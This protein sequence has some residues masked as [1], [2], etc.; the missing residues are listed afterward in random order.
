MKWSEAESD[1]TDR[2]RD[3]MHLACIYGWINRNKWEQERY[4]CKIDKSPFPESSDLVCDQME[5]SQIIRAMNSQP[6]PICH[7]LHHAYGDMQ[8]PD[9]TWHGRRVAYA[10]WVRAFP[11]KRDETNYQLIWMALQ[12]FRQRMLGRPPTSEEVLQAGMGG[13]KWAWFK[14]WKPKFEDTIDQLQ[15][16]DVCG[17]AHVSITVKA[18][19]EGRDQSSNGT[20]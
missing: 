15:A 17:V 3:A 4:G 2:T 12:D 14:L 8:A 10:L 18:I 20:G 1:G 5:A 19:R 7:W 13:K 6:K 11:E 16:W 9:W